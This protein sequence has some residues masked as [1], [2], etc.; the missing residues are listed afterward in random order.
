MNAQY[1]EFNGKHPAVKKED[2]EYFDAPNKYWVSYGCSYDNGLLKVDIDDYSH[3]TNELEE[4]IHGKPR[5][6]A[7]VAMLDSLGIRYNGIKT[8][9]GKQLFFRKPIWLEEK[10][11]INWYTPI[12]VKCEWKFPASDDHI[13]LKINGV[14]R[15]FF[16]GSI[17]NTDVDE[18]PYFLY[19]LQKYKAKSFDLTFTEGD[20]TQKL[21]AYLFHLVQNKYSAEQAYEIVRL[22][23]SYVFETPIPE[24]RLEAE[25]LNDATL[26]KLKGLQ[27]Q[28]ELT[29]SKVASD[30]VEQFMLIRT[31]SEYYCYSNGVY[32]P[33]D[34]GKIRQYVTMRYPNKTGN[35]ERE[36]IRHV[37]GQSHTEY[38]NDNK[39]VNV[40]NCLLSFAVN[41]DVSSMPHTRDNIS[42]RQFNALYD[43]TAKSAFLEE[44][45]LKWFNDDSAQIE[46]LN[47][48]LGYLMMNHVHYQKIFFFVGA[49]STGKSTLLNLITEFCGRE[50][51]SAIQLSDMNQTHAL[52]SIV[53]KTANI[54][55]DLKRSKVLS[56]ETFKMLADGSSIQINAKY[57][58]PFMYRYTGKMLF[59]MNNYPDFSHD[60]DGIERRLVIFRFYHV[61]KNGD[62]DFN[63]GIS[64]ELTSD[65]CLS[66]LLNHAISGYKTLIINKGF[67]DTKESKREL[68]E[69]IVENDSVVR[70]LKE[71]EHDEEHLLREPININGAKGL[72]PDYK[73]FCFNIGEEPRE[74]RAFTSALCQRYNL[75]PCLKRIQQDR[76]RFLRRKK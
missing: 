22:M 29:P 70:W 51:V 50:N 12:G 16:R 73:A 19:P 53:N 34:E 47:Q 43:P 2:R 65:S 14:E 66:A 25:I 23:N 61:F 42:F 40:R 75:E 39:C 33:F 58:K 11:K 8:E 28:K 38:P 74:Q 3:K 17:D 21:G 59:G 31:N 52:S 1:I 32:K 27:T 67:T 71:S 6:E 46:L 9:H 37:E 5:S 26:D 69:F 44:T 45:L 54:F 4:P 76:I 55:A 60:F 63:P 35:F 36:V 56:S 30:I 24:D 72:Y 62:T 41:G 48:V 57:K 13:P 64:D 49:P 68:E 18:L 20:R 10:N 7:V 15:A